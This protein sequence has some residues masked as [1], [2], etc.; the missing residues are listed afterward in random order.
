MGSV[1]SVT[2]KQDV[3]REHCKSVVRDY[4]SILKTK[5]SPLVIDDDKEVAKKSIGKF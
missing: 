3:L 5:L 2:R 4:D 1:E